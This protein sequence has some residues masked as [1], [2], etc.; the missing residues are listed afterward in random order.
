MQ[1]F[2]KCVVRVILWHS[3]DKEYDA[4]K[5]EK[6]K[7]IETGVSWKEHTLTHT[8][9]QP[10][11][12]FKLDHTTVA[13]MFACSL[14]SHIFIQ[15]VEKRKEQTKEWKDKNAHKKRMMKGATTTAATAASKSTHNY[16]ITFIILC[17]TYSPLWAIIMKNNVYISFR[18]IDKAKKKQQKTNN[19]AAEEELQSAKV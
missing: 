11:R 5:H 9:V 13:N 2:L 19:R 3:T 6:M 7:L 14:F 16:F 12:H 4:K 15:T 1:S 8:H 17:K 10:N 18:R